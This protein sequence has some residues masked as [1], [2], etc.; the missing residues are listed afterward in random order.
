LVSMT[1][2]ERF[3]PAT[4]TWTQTGSHSEHFGPA[5]ALLGDGRVVLAGGYVLGSVTGASLLYA[6][7]TNQWTSTGA[8]AAPRFFAKAIT[9]PDGRAL[10][11]AGQDPGSTTMTSCEW[12]GVADAGFAAAMDAGLDAGSDGGTAAGTDGG[13]DGGPDGGTDAGSDAG[14]E[15]GVD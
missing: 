15:V 14:S 2:G 8:M 12:Y 6:P 7:A 11:I 9:A 1:F 4:N 13:P 5:V 3:N 10:V